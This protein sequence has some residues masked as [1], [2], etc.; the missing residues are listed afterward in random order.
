MA[1]LKTND[2]YNMIAANKAQ[3]DQVAAMSKATPTF[4]D[5]MQSGI[6]GQD[7]TLASATSNYGDAVAQLFAHDKSLAG[8]VGGADTGI[9]PE[10]FVANPYKASMASADLYAQKGLEVSNALKTLETRKA[11][12]GDVVQKAVDAYKYAVASKQISVDAGAKSI[13]QLSRLLSDAESTRHNKAMEAQSAST[14]AEG[15]TA[16]ERLRNDNLRQLASDVQNGA[17]IT[18]V[19]DRYAKDL[20]QSDILEAYNKSGYGKPKENAV[21]LNTMYR[22]A[23]TGGGALDLVS[24]I[25]NKQ[26]ANTVASESLLAADSAKFIDELSPQQN[27]LEAIAKGNFPLANKLAAK[28]GK[29]SVWYSQ[30]NAFTANV[31]KNYYGSA[32]T[33]TE[34]NVAKQW[35]ANPTTQTGNQL[36]ASLIAHNLT[37]KQRIATSLKSVG[38]TDPNYI[39]AYLDQIGAN[40]TGNSSSE[41]DW[42]PTGNTK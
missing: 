2:L 12:L 9:A 22:A 6:V 11:V 33:S 14:I 28:F 5:N 7:K 10:G 38:I 30:L 29:D 34:V 15:K 31:I 20:D 26:V 42:V 36:Y 35:I 40:P 25:P 24:V 32:F 37:A 18:D 17:T 16:K 23:K 21:T 19:M 8:S 27:Y 3:A 39:N 13:D 4:Q 41:G 1:D